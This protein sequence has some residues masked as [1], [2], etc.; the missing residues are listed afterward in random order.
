[1]ADERPA[2]ATA[3]DIMAHGMKA[4]LRSTTERSFADQ[5]EQAA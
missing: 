4:G 1:M 2:G 3:P 5:V